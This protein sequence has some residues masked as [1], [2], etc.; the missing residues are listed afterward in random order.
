MILEFEPRFQEDAD[1]LSRPQDELRGIGK[2]FQTS[3]ASQPYLVAAAILAVYIVLGILF[4]G[5]HPPGSELR[6]PLGNI[7]LTYHA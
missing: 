1:S 3:L 4:R 7:R 2:V 5:L 6:R